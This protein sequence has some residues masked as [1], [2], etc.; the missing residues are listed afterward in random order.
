MPRDLLR[1]ESARDEPEDLDLPVG[2]RKTGAR[3]AKQNAARH[4]PAQK[5]AESH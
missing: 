3:T 4:G 5:Y 1:R 2:Q